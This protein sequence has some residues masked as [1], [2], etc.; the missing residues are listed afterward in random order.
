MS[1]AP[2]SGFLR[3]ARCRDRHAQFLR[4]LRL[5]QIKV[6]VVQFAVLA[7]FLGLWQTRGDAALIDPFIT[8]QPYRDCC[9]S[10]WN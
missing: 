3:A 1:D 10:S 5:R 4:A 2:S 6:V 7:V 9:R 8:S